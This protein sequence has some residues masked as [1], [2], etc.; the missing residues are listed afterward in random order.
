MSKY[1]TID[2]LFPSGAKTRDTGK[3]DIDS[4]FKGTSLN[5]NNKKNDVDVNSLLDSITNQRK[6]KLKIFIE[7][8]NKCCNQIRDAN[9]E[10]CT[11]I[12]FTVPEILA[13]SSSYSPVACI[14]YI[15]KNLVENLIDVVKL[16][17]CTIFIT[18]IDLELKMEKL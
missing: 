9:K 5:Y 18:W 1:I 17:D 14:E 11:D 16:N 3:I 13:E 8:Y 15:T 2:T 4:L 6:K 12:V 7:Y 10:G